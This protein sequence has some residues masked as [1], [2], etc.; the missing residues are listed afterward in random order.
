MRLE[1]MACNL[2][3]SAKYLGEQPV[4]TRISRMML[5]PNFMITPPGLVVGRILNQIV[6]IQG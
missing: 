2:Q 3:G 6:V 1:F 5:T 4:T